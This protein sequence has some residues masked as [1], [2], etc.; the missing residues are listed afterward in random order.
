MK[1]KTLVSII[2]PVYNGERYIKEAIES[3]INQTYKNWELIIVNDGSRDTTEKIIKLFDEKRIKYIY[4]ENR[5]VSIARNKGLDIAKGE[6]ITFL[7]ADD[8]LPSRSIEARVKYL[9][10]NKDIDIVDGIVLIKDEKLHKTLRKYKPYYKG[11]L[12]PKLLKLDDRVFFNVSYFLRSKNYDIRFNEKM[13]HVE[14]LL[15]YI[16]LSKEYNLV[17]GYIDEE[18]L[19]YRSGNVSAISNLDGIENGY[20]QLLKKLE[21]LKMNK[22]SIL[23]LQFKLSKIMFLT[24]INN[25]NY[26]KAFK[27]V[28]KFLKSS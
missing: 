17:Y 18:V 22:Q 20:L 1:E 24:W 11:K 7:D 2:M 3:V 9:N 5:G 6:F 21:Y 10:K 23:Y 13:T 12:L 14:D 19:W 4:Q 25:K 27:S 15:F 16:E 8:F 26:V 28:F